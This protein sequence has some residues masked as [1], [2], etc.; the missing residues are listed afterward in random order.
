MAEEIHLEPPSPVRSQKKTSF[1]RASSAHSEQ[2]PGWGQGSFLP[3]PHPDGRVSAASSWSLLSFWHW[4]KEPPSSRQR[5]LHCLAEVHSLGLRRRSQGPRANMDRVVL[6]ARSSVSSVSVSLL[7]RS[8][9]RFAPS[10]QTRRLE[11]LPDYRVASEVQVT[12]LADRYPACIR[13]AE[14]SRVHSVHLALH[15]FSVG[16]SR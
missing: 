2:Q 8:R 9:H 14:R 4:L 15:G 10:D 16:F 11:T 7:P 12:P 6:K 5:V 13:C 3:T 1:H